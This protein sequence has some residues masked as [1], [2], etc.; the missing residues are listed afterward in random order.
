LLL[1]RTFG[2]AMDYIDLD[3]V[4]EAFAS[5]DRKKAPAG[6]FPVIGGG[7]L[8]SQAVAMMEQHYAA[9]SHVFE[10]SGVSLFA[11]RD[12]PELFDVEA[13]AGLWPA[14]GWLQDDGYLIGPEGDVNA[15]VTMKLGSSLTCGVPFF[16]D[17][18]GWHDHDS[19]LVLWHYGGAPSLAKDVAD[20][21]YGNEGREVQFTLKPG[22]ATLM[23]VGMFKSSFR[24]LGITGQ[25][26][27]KTLQIGRAGGYFQ[28]TRTPAGQVIDHILENGWEHHYI[29]F[30]GDLSSE[31]KTLSKLTALPLTLL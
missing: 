20:I 29:L 24:L 11:I 12:W 10:H 27:D 14:L 16:S 25:I 6:R 4:K 5:Q 21:H 15:A 13:P 17:V 31:L 1:R 18:S 26:L 28:T 30:Y 8:G 19:S 23:R 3:E 9:L 2:L 7:E 22:K